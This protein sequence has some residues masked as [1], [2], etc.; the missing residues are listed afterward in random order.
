MKAKHTIK[1]DIIELDKSEKYPEEKVLPDVVLYR[2][3]YQPAEQHGDQ[4]RE[5]N[6]FIWKENTF[7]LDQL[8]KQLGNHGSYYL[9]NESD[10]A[11]VREEL[12]HIPEILK[13]LLNG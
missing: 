13:Y 7:T 1:L 11:F 6:N 4:K 2:Y 12:M 9:Q 5:A 10:R 8:V 3:L